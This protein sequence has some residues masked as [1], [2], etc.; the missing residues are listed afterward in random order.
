MKYEIDGVEY[1]MTQLQNILSGNTAKYC[2]SDGN[3]IQSLQDAALEIMESLE[4][5]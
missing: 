1:T 3:P 4:G 5:E 2:D